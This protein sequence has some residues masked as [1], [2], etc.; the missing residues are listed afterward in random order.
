M[1]KF[2]DEPQWYD[3]NGVLTKPYQGFL[4]MVAQGTVDSDGKGAYM[5][6]NISVVTPA[7]QNYVVHCGNGARATPSSVIDD[8]ED[9]STSVTWGVNIGG[10]GTCYLLQ[11]LS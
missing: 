4:K 11:I 8:A 7:S 3:K 10:G 1:P 2:L 6:P 9:G 5:T